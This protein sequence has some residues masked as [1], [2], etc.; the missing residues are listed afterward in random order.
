MLD[1]SEAIALIRYFEGCSLRSYL[2]PAGVWTIGW[3][4]T[5]YLDGDRVERGD[6][7][8]QVHADALNLQTIRDLAFDLSEVISVSWDQYS[9]AI[10][11]LAYNIG[12][13]NYAR[14]TFNSLLHDG[15]TLLHLQHQLRRWNKVDGKISMGLVRR[16]NCE[17]A[18]LA[19]LNWREHTE[20]FKIYGVDATTTESS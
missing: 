16:R 20:D 5:F 3:G 7:I 15:S 14:S 12:I 13:D 11:S 18:A 9:V 17:A 19:G 8:S 10:L 2:C 6:S 1:V 4:N